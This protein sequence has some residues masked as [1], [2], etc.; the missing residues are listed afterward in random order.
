MSQLIFEDCCFECGKKRYG[1]TQL[2]ELMTMHSG[3]CPICKKKKIIIPA[4]DWAGGG[5]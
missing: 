2:G 4:S 3:W 5:D 1:S